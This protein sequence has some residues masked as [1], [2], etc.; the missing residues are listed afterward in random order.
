MY[1][2]RSTVCFITVGN[3]FI[4]VIIHV[5]AVMHRNLYISTYFLLFVKVAKLIQWLEEA[6]EESEEE[7]E[8]D[9]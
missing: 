5:A 2:C 9:S 4:H 1:I 7:T 6:E 3:T 8:D